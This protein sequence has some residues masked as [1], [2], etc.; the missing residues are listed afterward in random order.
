MQWTQQAA[1]MARVFLAIVTSFSVVESAYAFSIDF[2][3]FYLS[4]SLKISSQ[5]TST[6]MFTDFALML[7]LD[8]KGTIVAGWN[9]GII[10][11]SESGSSTSDFSVSEM[12]PKFGWYMDKAREW[13]LG[14]TYNLQST[15]TYSA[16]GSSEAEW[17]GTS[18]KVEAGWTPQVSEG[19]YI[20]LKLNYYAAS[21]SE[22][23]TGT[24]DYSVISNSRSMIYPSISMTYR[25]D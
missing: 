7:N 13:Y 5:N 2:N 9:Y 15:A 4:D 17:R 11:V 21:F 18:L 8:R 23:L 25:L 1:K 12:G 16:S 10:S 19:F 14:L 24:T 3:G 6:K 20:G 22:S